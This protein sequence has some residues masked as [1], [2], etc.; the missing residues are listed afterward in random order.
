[1]SQPIK[2]EIKDEVL[3][4]IRTTGMSVLEAGKLYGVSTKAI[5]NWLSKENLGVPNVLAVNQLRQKT[6]KLY[7]IIGKLTAEIESLKKGRK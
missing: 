7:A 5:Y 3:H 4:K 1:M 2:K 6:E